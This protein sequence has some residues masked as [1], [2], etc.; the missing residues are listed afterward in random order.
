MS[1]F[2]EMPMPDDWHVHLR[3][4]MLMERVSD[5]SGQQFLNNLV[6][7]NLVPPLTTADAVAEYYRLLIAHARTLDKV[8]TRM[9]LYLTSETAAADIRTAHPVAIAAKY[10][11]Q[12]GTTNSRAGLVTPRDLKP[13]TLEAMQDV[14]MVL[15]LHAELTPQDESD[16]QAREAGFIPHLSWLVEN[17]PNLRIVVE[18]VSDRR[19]LDFVFELPANVAATITA[20]HPFITHM[21]AIHDPHCN[22]MPIAKTPDDRD[23]LAAIILEAAT[24]RKI[25]FGSDSAP[26]LIE[27]KLG[28]AAGVWSSPVAIPVLWQH[29]DARGG[30]NR[31]DNFIAFMCQNGADFYRVGMPLERRPRIRLL[32]ERWRVPEEYFGLRPWRAGEILDWRV[33]SVG[34]LTELGGPVEED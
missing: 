24:H 22:C 14:G 6:M 16:P 18:H 31:W 8:G 32:R 11:P 33:D 3:D 12:G 20:H 26:H 27:S 30:A 9:T 5:I 19:M 10:Y 15:C 17:Y 23:Y 28:G 34:W 21:D 7:P 25:F 29:F 13:E 1:I 4:G 2:V